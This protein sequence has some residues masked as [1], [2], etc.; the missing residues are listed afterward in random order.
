MGKGGRGP[1]LAEAPFAP[2][3][4]LLPLPRG[5]GR[6][7]PLLLRPPSR[8]PARVSRPPRPPG[9][10]AAGR[11]IR[12]G[13]G[14]AGSAPLAPL[15][16]FLPRRRGDRV[17][18]RSG[19]FSLLPLLFELQ[20]RG[21]ARSWSVSA[22]NAVCVRGALPSDSPGPPSALPKILASLPQLRMSQTILYAVSLSPTPRSP[23]RG[24]T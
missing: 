7:A 2:A 15:L 10:P 5:P 11:C 24:F 3:F 14:A 22:L 16:A 13:D 21:F 23:P 1:E 17:G 9:P 6:R 20:G 8:P 18:R 4:S 12:A 19:K